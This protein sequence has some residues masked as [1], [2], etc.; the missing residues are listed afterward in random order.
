MPTNLTPA[1]LTRLREL[2]RAFLVL[3]T[4][5]DLV[6][7][8][9]E[10]QQAIEDAVWPLIPALLDAAE[11]RDAAILALER[12][13]YR[14]SCDIPACNCGDTWAHGGNAA[15]RLRE[16]SDAL[17]AWTQGRTLLDAVRTLVDTA[18]MWMDR[19]ENRGAA[20]DGVAAAICAHAESRPED[21]Q[22][23]GIVRALV[24]E[25]DAARR[26]RNDLREAVNRQKLASKEGDRR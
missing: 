23:P 18:D 11:D 25:H 9:I 12:H 1:D 4:D 3:D 5:F 16:I 15:T 24:E 22:L 8:A 2:E 26:E 14:R 20:L 7:S 21:D 10:A 19:A 6:C 17:G 13:G